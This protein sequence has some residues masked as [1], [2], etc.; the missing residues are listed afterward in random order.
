MSIA[1]DHMDNLWK[2]NCEFPQINHIHSPFLPQID[3][4]ESTGMKNACG[5]IIT[6]FN[7]EYDFNL[8]LAAANTRA[9]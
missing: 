1:S 7:S 9:F 3:V 5:A 8:N 2:S 4:I 6:S